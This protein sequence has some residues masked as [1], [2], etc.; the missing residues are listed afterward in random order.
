MSETILEA[1]L[2]EAYDKLDDANIKYYEENKRLKVNL[3]NEKSI[4]QARESIANSLTNK[5]AELVEVLEFYA[6]VSSW[7]GF[8]IE[9]DW[10]LGVEG[11]YVG[12][13]RARETLA[14]HKARESDEKDL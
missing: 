13:K 7:N 8:K 4:S 11:F 9:D 2:K 10:T 12:G 6:D 3:S 1:N 5:N 14:K